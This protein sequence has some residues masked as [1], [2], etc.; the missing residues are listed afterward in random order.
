MAIKTLGS[1]H[2]RHLRPFLIHFRS[3][4]LIYTLLP[5]F[6]VFTHQLNID[7]QSVMS[8]AFVMFHEHPDTLK[9]ITDQVQKAIGEVQN[10]GHNGCIS[11]ACFG[12]AIL[13][14]FN[15]ILGVIDDLI[16][17][18]GIVKVAQFIAGIIEV[19]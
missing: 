1:I 19:I 3:M 14:R 17:K 6:L 15:S 11:V 10:F 9:S 16:G 8:I 7:K 13:S 18:F 2:L 12:A 4:R 5:N